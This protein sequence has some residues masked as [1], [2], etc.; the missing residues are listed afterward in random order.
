MKA[1]NKVRVYLFVFFGLAVLVSTKAFGAEPKDSGD[2]I[3]MI[4]F[5]HAGNL[6]KEIPIKSKFKGDRIIASKV[7]CGCLSLDI[8][9]RRL[10]KN[11]KG[12]Y[13]ATFSL[14]LRNEGAPTSGEYFVHVELD[15]SG[16]KRYRVVYEIFP[17]VK[18]NPLV[19]DMSEVQAGDLRKV[20]VTNMYLEPIK[21]VEISQDIPGLKVED[22][23]ESE[24]KC[25]MQL[26]LAEESREIK[27]QDSLKFLRFSIV[28]EDETEANGFVYLQ[29]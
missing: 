16:T 5:C 22:R 13:S 27:I 7:G 9:E 24:N 23:I 29:F 15:K 28:F 11:K 6:R 10:L 26:S 17:S 18:I 2:S 25:E 8:P 21:S 19:V 4:T 20:V 12:T 3:H 14:T 1:I